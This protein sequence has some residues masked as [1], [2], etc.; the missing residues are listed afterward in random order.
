MILEAAGRDRLVLLCSSP[1]R[2]QEQWEFLHL[3]MGPPAPCMPILQPTPGRQRVN[4]AQEAAGS[5]FLALSNNG[6]IVGDWASV[7]RSQDWQLLN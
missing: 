2:T 5:L 1:P 7:G 6:A 4:D 3:P